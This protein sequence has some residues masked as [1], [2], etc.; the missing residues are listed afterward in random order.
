MQTLD[1]DV[2]DALGVEGKIVVAAGKVGE[3]A[4]VLALD[5]QH[6]AAYLLVVGKADEFFQLFRLR[7]VF[8]AAQQL[9]DQA[10]QAGVDLGEPAAV[11][12][13]VG[14]ISKVVGAQRAE[15]AEEVVAQDLAVQAGHA[16]DLIAG[17]KAEIGHQHLVVAD[18]Q[19]ASHALVL[20]KIINQVVDPA[21]VDLTE[22]LPDAGQQL[23]DDLLG[24]ALQRLAH[25]RV[26]G[27][28]HA[29]LHDLPGLVPAQ[30]VLVHEE[31][32]QLGDNQRRVRIV[33]LDRVVLAEGADVAPLFDVLAHDVLRGGGDEEI[34]LLETQDLAL[35]LLVGGIEHLGDDLG[36]RAL[37]EALDVLGVGEEIHVELAG[38]LR[39][40]ETQ[41]VDLL[42]LIARDQ[43]VARDRDDGRVVGMLGLVVAVAVPVRGDLAAETDLDRIVI[44]RDEP[45]LGR[46]APVVGDLGLA[47][48]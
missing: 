14:D 19:V 30:A 25:D 2:H 5:G 32:H 12:D 43:H 17:R 29:L 15:V 33:D 36:H 11:V 4:L 34:L 7:Q 6:A 31:P 9:T 10:V 44:A 46:E 27:I 38:A 3:A 41:L 21:A 23:L 35:E 39:V 47:A 22:D 37:L 24:P 28:G 48:V 42:A 18:D 40:P 45:A 13:T 26:V 1:L 20:A 8:L 16:V